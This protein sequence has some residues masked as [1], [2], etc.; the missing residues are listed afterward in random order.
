[1]QDQSQDQEQ[2]DDVGSG[3]RPRREFLVGTGV[4]T[5]QNSGDPNPTN[6]T[7]FMKRRR[8]FGLVPAID[9]GD[10]IGKSC[11]FWN[12]YEEDI[13]RA[14]ALNSTCFRLSL[15]WSRL[16]PIPGT[17]DTTAAA[18]FES[19]IQC[20]RSK[21]MEPIVTLSHF[22]YPAWWFA[23]GGWEKESNVPA[24]LRY[25][26]WAVR[27]F[28]HL[29]RV[30]TT[31]NEPG[32]VTLACYVGGIHPPGARLRFRRAARV[33]QNQLIA[34][35]RAYRIIKALPGGDDLQVGLVH[36]MM[37]FQAAYEDRWYSFYYKI[38]VGRRQAYLLEPGRLPLLDCLLLV[39][40]TDLP[41]AIHPQGLYKAIREASAL[42]VPIYITESGC[43]DAK[44][45][46]RRKEF[47]T[48]YLQE[49]EKA[50]SDGFDVRGF[51]YWT[52]T[53]NYEWN[54]GYTI[55]FGLYE[56]NKE[57]PE[58]RKLREGSKAIIKTYERRVGAVRWLIT[59]LPVAL[60]GL[61]VAV[62][63]GRS[64]VE[65]SRHAKMA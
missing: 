8:F 65:K 14:R 10:A 43:P 41:Y 17:F 34:H 32:I 3:V 64:D 61:V 1:M 24:F 57:K 36:N 42:K 31:M 26:E 30:W 39:Q 46:G 35:A 38:P 6:W 28:Q 33:F 25:A 5:W 55:K 51:V 54:T 13:E 18:H 27:R 37:E 9:G 56:W 19:I 48:S 12:R 62:V 20:I 16:E 60:A 11:D 49:V 53:D 52:L 45:D 29:V 44:D 4:S 23:E 58:E 7:K 47:I 63:R 22:V 21:G 50:V 59:A 40:M 2:R 15:E